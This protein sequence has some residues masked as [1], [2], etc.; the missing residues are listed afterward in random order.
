MFVLI[1]EAIY[2]QGVVGIY[3]N[4]DEAKAVAEELWRDSDGHHG[5]RIEERT[6]GVTC[7][8]FPRQAT[9]VAQYQRF[10][11]EEQRLRIVR[12][13]EFERIEP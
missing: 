6:L 11:T 5:F 8:V 10:A 9:S 3:E 4:L 13:S 7:D 2:D 1:A 12:E